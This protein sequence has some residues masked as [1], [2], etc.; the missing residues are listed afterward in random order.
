MA[1]TRIRYCQKCG[2]VTNKDFEDATINGWFNLKHC[3]QCYRWYFKVR[4]FIAKR[5]GES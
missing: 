3:D 2:R 4:P 1:T 5:M